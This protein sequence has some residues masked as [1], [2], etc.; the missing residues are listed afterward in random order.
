M[1]LFA[2]ILA[3]ILAAAAVIFGVVE[4]RAGQERARSFAASQRETLKNV[5]RMAK[6]IPDW[7]AFAKADADS[8]R[9]ARAELTTIGKA[10]LSVA[11][12]PLTTPEVKKRA[13]AVVDEALA[14]EKALR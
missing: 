14:A 8:A 3:A 5:E 9:I 6:V 10:V 1:K 4:W 12:D 13:L 7:V 2:I 11:S